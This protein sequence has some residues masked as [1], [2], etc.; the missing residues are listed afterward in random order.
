MVERINFIGQQSSK[1]LCSGKI[2]SDSRNLQGMQ[3]LE[4]N[5]KEMNI[6]IPEITETGMTHQVN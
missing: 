5:K 6:T 4:S 2:V 1:V 3:T